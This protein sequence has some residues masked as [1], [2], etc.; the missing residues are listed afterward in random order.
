MTVPPGNRGQA[1]TTCRPGT[2]DGDTKAWVGWQPRGA[3]HGFVLRPA[4]DVAPRYPV[5]P[6]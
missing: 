3:T 2:P 5:R 4:T 1:H 6:R